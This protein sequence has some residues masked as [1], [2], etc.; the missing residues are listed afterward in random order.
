MV[1][2]LWNTGCEHASGVARK[3]DQKSEAKSNYCSLTREN[4]IVIAAELDRQQL[5]LGWVQ[6]SFRHATNTHASMSAE[7]LLLKRACYH[8]WT[9]VGHLCQLPQRFA[10][11]VSMSTC[12]VGL[13]Q[14][15]LHGGQAEPACCCDT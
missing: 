15:P 3:A 6:S 12:D 2:L 10:Y 9:S 7:K 5:L 14:L 8:N 11:L 1:N 13:L 4:L